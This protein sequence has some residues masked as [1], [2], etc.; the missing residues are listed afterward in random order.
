MATSDE[1]NSIQRLNSLL[2]PASPVNSGVK[3]LI[4]YLNS[5]Q[6]SKPLPGL[7]LSPLAEAVD[8]VKE[9][10]RG[11]QVAVRGEL[12]GWRLFEK[13][14][15]ALTQSYCRNFA[16]VTTC[17]LQDMGWSLEEVLAEFAHASP[18]YSAPYF[19]AD[20]ATAENFKPKL[21][22]L[23]YGVLIGK[24]LPIVRDEKITSRERR[25]LEVFLNKVSSGTLL[26]KHN[27]LAGIR[28]RQTGL[29]YDDFAEVSRD[30]SSVVIYHG[31]DKIRGTRNLLGFDLSDAGWLLVAKLAG[32]M[33]PNKFDNIYIEQKLEEIS[34]HLMDEE[35]SFVQRVLASVLFMNPLRVTAIP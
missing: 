31:T 9:M 5:E 22:V 35:V 11:K 18:Y 2:R 6:S 30:L 14:Y 23:A 32:E 34:A 4:N 17:L 26:E 8:E 19:N 16:W 7:F 20:I 10:R 33:F 1:Y 21:S 28:P 27:R 15:A 24:L 12:I 13:L 3:R 25:E 29:T